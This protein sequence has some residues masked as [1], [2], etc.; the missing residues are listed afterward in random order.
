MKPNKLTDKQELFCLY[1]IKNFN[2]TQ[3]YLKAYGCSYNVANVEGYKS[4]VNPSIQKEIQRLKIEKKKAIMLDE[5]DIVERYMRIAFADVTDFVEFGRVT[6]PVM[7]AFGPIEILNKETG[8]KETLTKEINEI[9]LKESNMVD[10]GL[11]CQVKQGKDGA[12]IKLEDRMKALE[13]LSNFFNMNPMDNHKKEYD[14]RKL[15][16]E[17]I[18]AESQLN[19]TGDSPE[20]ITGDDGFIEALNATVGEAWDDVE[21]D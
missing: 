8:K 14:K 19:K 5:D 15:E 9:R 21:S 7:G 11:I 13:W 2:A 18:K 1:Y 10:G 3:A 16:I 17:L 12:S 6:V 4:L 20:V